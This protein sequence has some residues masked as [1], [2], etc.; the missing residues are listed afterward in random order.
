MF[1]SCGWNNDVWINRLKKIGLWWT[2]IV[3]LLFIAQAVVFTVRANDNY[4]LTNTDLQEQYAEA[5]ANE[6]DALVESFK[7]DFQKS[8]SAIQN[9]AM[10]LQATGDQA[11]MQQLKAKAQQTQTE[12]ME[13]NGPDF[14]DKANAV[15]A[16]FNKQCPDLQ[17][18]NQSIMQLQSM[19]MQIQQMIAMPAAMQAPQAAPAAEEAPATEAEQTTNNTDSIN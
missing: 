2:S 5:W 15:I 8:M 12:F 6:A 14:V 9:E 7:G 3:V 4:Y 11:A 10:E 13:K 1:Q 16:S 17:G 18:T 19:A